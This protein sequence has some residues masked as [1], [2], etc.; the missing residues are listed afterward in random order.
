MELT[1]P[2]V[3]VGLQYNS[4]LLPWFPFTELRVD[5]FEIFLDSLAGALDTPYVL[6]P[7]ALD[8][9]QPLRARGA[10]LIA[11]SNFGGEF[12]FGPLEETVAVR[13]HVP[14]SH[15]ID[16]P[17][18]ADHC[19]YCDSSRAEMWSSPVQ[20]SRAEV[21]RLAPR[22]RALQERYGMPLCHENAAYYLPVPGSDMPEAEFLAELVEAAGTYLLLD[23]HNVYANS[24]NLP[25]YRCDEF[26]A[27]IP[28]DRVVEIHIGGGTEL[29]GF[30]HDWH[31]GAVPEPVWEM[32]EQVLAAARVGAV[33]LEFQGR[34]HDSETRVLTPQ[35]DTEVIFA[36]VERAIGLWERAYGRG[37]RV[38]HRVSA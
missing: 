9:L 24:R 18:V 33:I 28:L 13:R 19:F 25:G 10:A 26:L 23:L 17:W 35:R 5:A 14:L 8:G 1:Y 7:G 15:M 20:L 3:G 2:Q 34:A 37:S 12:G 31:D 6:Y 32:V 30:Y 36:D 38:L 4:G 29:G 21:A 11:H 16:S 22:A 27:R